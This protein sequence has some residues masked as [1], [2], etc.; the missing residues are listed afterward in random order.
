MQ[1][2]IRWQHGIVYEIYSRSFSGSS[3]DGMADLS[4]KMTMAGGD[5]N[6]PGV[7]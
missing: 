2:S 3:W 6:G 4:V 1:E 7:D 5:A